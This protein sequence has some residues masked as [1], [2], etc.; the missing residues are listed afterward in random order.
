MN[1]VSTKPAP[2]PAPAQLSRPVLTALPKPS[3]LAPVLANLLPPVLILLAFLGLWEF[4]ASGP[5]ATLPPP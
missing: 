5:G 1:A 2:A 4:L 3:R